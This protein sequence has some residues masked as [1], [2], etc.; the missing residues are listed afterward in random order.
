M[1]SGVPGGL[2]RSFCV[3][4]LQLSDSLSSLVLDDA[5]RRS[6]LGYVFPLFIFSTSQL[7]HYFLHYMN[8]SFE[9]IGQL[10]LIGKS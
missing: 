8:T 2:A 10:K 7:K 3:R 1:I 9:K 6:R 4:A 5:G